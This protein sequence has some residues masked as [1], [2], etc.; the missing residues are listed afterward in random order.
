[1]DT[2]PRFLSAVAAVLFLTAC[3]YIGAGLFQREDIPMQEEAVET[4]PPCF[5]FL[6]GIAVRSELLLPGAE[7][8]SRV[9]D[10]ERVR[11]GAVLYADVFAESS[12]VFF[13]SSDGYEY[14]CPAMLEEL[15]TKGLH[16]LLSAQPQET[17]AARFVTGYAWYIAAFS[18]RPLPES[19][20]Y[21]FY[22]DGMGK[23]IPAEIVSACTEN[24]KTAVVLRL[25]DGTPE[26]LS[27]RK[28][29]GKIIIKSE[30]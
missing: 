30:K 8:M 18:D 15:D 25:T 22:P 1:M 17:D 10:G 5:A 28:I 27:V 4:A 21:I 16:E 23:A 2:G 11:R 26:A 12:G 7:G 14:L 24:G 9:K 6:D 20:R 19:G 29:T 3:A 13:E